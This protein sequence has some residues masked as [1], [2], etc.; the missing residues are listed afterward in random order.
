MEINPGKG[1]FNK[2]LLAALI[3]GTT[4][5]LLLFNAAAEAISLEISEQV[6]LCLF[7]KNYIRHEDSPVIA[8]IRT[9]ATGSE[10]NGPVYPAFLIEQLK[11]QGWPFI[12][13]WSLPG[14]L[15][16]SQQLTEKKDSPLYLDKIDF[17]ESLLL[18]YFFP[19]P[20]FI[21]KPIFFKNATGGTAEISEEKF[22]DL[23]QSAIGHHS[24]FGAYLTN[25][26]IAKKENNELRGKN[27]VLEERLGNAETTI[28]IIR[29]KYK[30]DYNL[31]FN[32]YQKEYEVLPLWY[33]RFGHVLKAL[34]GHRSFKSL[35]NDAPKERSKKE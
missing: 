34:K 7:S 12:T 27:S 30:D 17:D 11:L 25:Y 33:K 6:N 13:V 24:L 31:L 32:W 14:S 19:E 29:T 18:D 23:C 20:D 26:L 2:D 4:P 10:I 35:F 1:K 9:E 8:F 15:S 5:F 21:G 28:E 3:D 22:S 16:F